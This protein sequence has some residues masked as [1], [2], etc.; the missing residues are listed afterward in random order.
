MCVRAVC[1]TSG[2]KWHKLPAPVVCFHALNAWESAHHDTTGAATEIVVILCQFTEFDLAM[3]SL[4]SVL[5]H[6]F[7]TY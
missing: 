7:I 2:T 6:R 4:E 5:L 3:V 1:A